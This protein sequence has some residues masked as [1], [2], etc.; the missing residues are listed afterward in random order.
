MYIAIGGQISY[1]P[2]VEHIV[3]W[4]THK[5]LPFCSGPI[6]IMSCLRR[7]DTR[8]SPRYIFAFSFYLSSSHTQNIESV[9]DIMDMEDEERNKLL[10]LTDAQMQVKIVTLSAILI[11]SATEQ[12]V[13]TAS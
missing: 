1:T 8:L 7:K 11:L 5:T 13:L 9:F 2:T 4:T 12:R 3:A 6:F 10:Q